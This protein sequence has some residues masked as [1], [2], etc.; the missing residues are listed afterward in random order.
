MLSVPNLPH[1]SVPVGRDATRECGGAPMGRAAEVR[2]RA[3]AALGS[4]RARRHPGSAARGE[5]RGGAFCALSR[6]GRAAG[7][8]AGQFLPGL[9]R[10]E[11][12]TEYLPPFLVNTASLTGVGPVAEVCRRHVSSGRHRSLADAH[13]GSGTHQPL[14]RRDAGRRIA[15]AEGLRVDGVLPLRGGRGGKR[16]ARHHCGSTSFKKWRCSSSRGP[17]RVTTSTKRW[18]RDA[19]VAAA[20]ARACTIA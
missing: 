15:A 13:G 4:G 10:E 1:P 6:T 8:G 12:Y 9:A 2:F 20:E 5:N 11:G 17:S 14:P 18:S 16:H 3:A 7:A 19:E